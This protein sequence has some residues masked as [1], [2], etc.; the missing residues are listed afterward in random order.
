[1][2]YECIFLRLYLNVLYIIHFDIVDMSNI[3]MFEEPHI[4]NDTALATHIS[5]Q[6]VDHRRTNTNVD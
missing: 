2:Q 6:T 4:A 5:P 1:M 3:Y